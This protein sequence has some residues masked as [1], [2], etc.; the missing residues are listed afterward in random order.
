MMKQ[1]ERA[2]Q[3][4]HAQTAEDAAPTADVAASPERGRPSGSGRL[5]RVRRWRI[6]FW[7]ALAVLA[8]ALVALAAILFSYQQGRS[9]Y[10]SLASDSVDVSALEEG[11][12]AGLADVAIDWDA[13]RE[14][15]PDVI[16]WIYIPGTAVNYPVV[17][18]GDDVKYLHTDFYGNENWVVSYGTVFLSGI[19]E[20]DL[21]DANNIVYGHH[22]NDGSMFAALADLTTDEAFNAHRTVYFFTPEG[23]IRLTSF[24][25]VHVPG[26]SDIAQATFASPQD[27]T[28][29]VQARMDESI[30]AA[31]G[32][33][34]QASEITQTFML[35]TCDEV[36]SGRYVL[37]CYVEQ[38]YHPHVVAVASSQA[39]GD[40]VVIEEDVA[41]VLEQA[42]QTQGGF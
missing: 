24:A 30:V 2:Y 34:P 1:D 22:M 18:S 40:D 21:S 6:V 5:R 42:Q 29:Y 10:E 12:D 17:Y 35:S 11:A 28:A 9:L 20:P 19:N 4:R 36:S 33:L 41:A 23:N 15:N 25:L 14:V 31:E 39:S 37:Y 27:Q 32:E 26:T 7:V 16:G 8:C 38:S 3:G 13:L